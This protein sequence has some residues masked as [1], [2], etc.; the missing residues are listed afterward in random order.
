MWVVSAV[1]KYVKAGEIVDVSDALSRLLSVD[2]IAKLGSLLPPA[3]SFRHDVCYTPEVTDVLR[4]HEGSLRT[5]FDALAR[6]TRVKNYVSLDVWLT[7]LRTTRIVQIDFSDRNAILCFSWSRMVS[8]HQTP[9]TDLHFPLVV[10][11]MSPLVT[12]AGVTRLVIH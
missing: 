11:V 8:S 3:D 5:I 10:G 1:D 4:R 6:A 9:P 12:S 7:F 2:L